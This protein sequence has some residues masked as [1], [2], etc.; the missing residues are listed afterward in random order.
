MDYGLSFSVTPY[1]ELIDNYIKPN[2]KK[3]KNGTW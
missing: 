1:K 3:I 2:V